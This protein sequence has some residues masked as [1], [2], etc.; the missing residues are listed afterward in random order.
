MAKMRPWKPGHAVPIRRVSYTRP[1]RP[2]V[3]GP[4]QESKRGAP[5]IP[6][7][8]PKRDRRTR[9]AARASISARQFEGIVSRGHSRNRKAEKEIGAEPKLAVVRD[10][11]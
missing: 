4:H 9:H 7:V 2:T 11:K 10:E 6:V 5:Q 1:D 8:V 3:S